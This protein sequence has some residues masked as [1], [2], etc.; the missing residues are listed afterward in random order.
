MRSRALPCA[1][2]CTALPQIPELYA[3]VPGWLRK[4]GGGAFP[5]TAVAF[6][7][8]I[9]LL[10]SSQTKKP[11]H[12]EC[13]NCVPNCGFRE[14]QFMPAAYLFASSISAVILDMD[15]VEILE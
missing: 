4:S 9:L 8:K 2:R 11:D 3:L 6:D 13:D 12:P 15:S 1:G 7:G 5:L 10:S 14:A